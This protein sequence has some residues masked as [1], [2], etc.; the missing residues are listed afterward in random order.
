VKFRDA[1]LPMS[2][3]LFDQRLYRVID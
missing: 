1:S 3:A 2:G